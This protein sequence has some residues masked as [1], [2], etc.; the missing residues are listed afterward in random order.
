MRSLSSQAVS[1]IVVTYMLVL[2][3]QQNDNVPALVFDMVANFAEMN[4]APAS[5]E[6]GF[7]VVARHP[8]HI[9]SFGSKR[10]AMLKVSALSHDVPFQ[11]RR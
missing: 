6:K 4:F 5:F 9:D 7:V 11:G 2:L 3:G 1:E 8:L 10:S